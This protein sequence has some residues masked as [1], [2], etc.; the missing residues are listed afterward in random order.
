[1]QHR[2]ERLQLVNQNPNTKEIVAA[3]TRA[4]ALRMKYA[5]TNPDANAK[6]QDE[7]AEDED[8]GFL[9]LFPTLIMPISRRFFPR[10]ALTKEEAQ[11]LVK[12]DYLLLHH[13]NETNDN[14]APRLQRS[15]ITKSEMLTQCPDTSWEQQQKDSSIENPFVGFETPEAN[16]FEIPKNWFN[17]HHSAVIG[18]VH[19]STGQHARRHSK[20][21]SWSHKPICAFPFGQHKCD[22]R[23][24]Y[25]HVFCTDQ[26]KQ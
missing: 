18:E 1:M 4:R 19:H 11:N 9:A 17:D 26:A 16:E 24:I 15:T 10:L 25:S 8:G 5:E 7:S 21:R 13:H 2:L 6:P 22:S 12:Y 3:I 14:A 23:G 20:Q